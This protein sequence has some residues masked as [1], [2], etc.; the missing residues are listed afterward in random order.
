MKTCARSRSPSKQYPSLHDAIVA[1]E[2]HGQL[3]WT[4]SA[5][6]GRSGEAR[7]AGASAYG[8]VGKT[9]K[10]VRSYYIYD[11]VNGWDLPEASL[12]RMDIEG[13]E[14]D[15]LSNATDLFSQSPI[16]NLIFEA[17]AAHFHIKQP[18]RTLQ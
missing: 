10:R 2:L 4:F 6:T 8:T 13:C 5:L 15:D 17:N 1:N 16:T 3:D 12:I 14:I 11:L 18:P 9:G 7:I